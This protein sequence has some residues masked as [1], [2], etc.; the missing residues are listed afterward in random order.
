MNDYIKISRNINVNPYKINSIC[1]KRNLSLQKKLSEIKHN[2]EQV[3]NKIN[4]TDKKIKNF[5]NINKKI[6]HPNISKKELKLNINPEM[7]NQVR[8]L[9]YQYSNN[10]NKKNYIKD[11][12]S[13][14]NIFLP[15]QNSSINNINNFNFNNNIFSKSSQNFH[16]HKM[17]SKLKTDSEIKDN[18]NYIYRTNIHTFKP[19]EIFLLNE[20]LQKQVIDMR[21]QLYD[22]EKKSDKFSE[23]INNLKNEKDDLN[24]KVYKLREELNSNIISQN[25]MSSEISKLN[26]IINEKNYLI[27]NLN[28]QIGLIIDINSMHNEENNI[29]NDVI[30]HESEKNNI[31]V[32]YNNINYYKNRSTNLKKDIKDLKIEF[33]KLINHNEN[34]SKNN[35]KNIDSE[36]INNNSNKKEIL[37][38]KEENEKLKDVYN[39]IKVDYDKIANK[40]KQL[41]GLTKEIISLKEDNEKLSKLNQQLNG[42]NQ[43]LKNENEEIN[44]ENKNNLSQIKQL[45]SFNEAQ[46]NEK[47]LLEKNLEEN[48][49]KTEDLI[50]KLNIIQKE[51]EI[52]INKAKNIKNEEQNNVIKN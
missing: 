22:S 40:N 52:N 9:S 34:N 15:T 31:N 42:I 32:Y 29:N 13:S 17:K 1:V 43:S 16:H 5:I 14:N 50:S 12:N 47:L 6:P 45:I 21:L 35:N 48:R 33:D 20:V 18:N 38:L 37:S 49:H 10:K 8:N 28:T 23:L 46:K 2:I 36:N 24:K 7:N 51:N 3:S 25:Q 44:L 39:K 27:Q 11:S 19:K 26:C 4:N 30:N 41:N